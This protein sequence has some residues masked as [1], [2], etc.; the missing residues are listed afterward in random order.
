MRVDKACE[1][2]GQVFQDVP[3]RIK[4][5]RYCSHR[6]K[7]L[8]QV[9]QQK[10]AGT[11]KK[12]QKPRRGTETPCPVCGKPVYATQNARARGVG[13]YCSHACHNVAQSQGKV[14]K[15]CA[16]CGKEMRLAP[17]YAHLEHCS[18][19]CRGDAL[20]A[21]PL[22][23]MHNGR[24][25]RLDSG[26]YVMLWEP[27]HPAAFHGWVYEHRILIEKMLGRYL[28][29]DEHVHHINGV[30]DDNRPENLQIMGWLEHLALSGE[31]HRGALKDAMA[32]LEEYRKRFGPL[33]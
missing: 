11:W 19:R 15:Q 32:E 12:P 25:A 33:K 16:R 20:I 8:V 10:A 4:K 18:R 21:R 17:T 6:C 23:R 26:G 27:E 7:M 30:K 22:G 13:V 5:R 29:S 28:A 9:R 1:E 14:I 3:S 24:P 31:E 2:C